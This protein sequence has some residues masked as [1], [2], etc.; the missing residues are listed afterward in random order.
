M[1]VHIF[2]ARGELYG[3]TRAADANNLP[4]D[5]APWVLLQQTCNPRRQ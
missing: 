3:F 1:R 2:K 5:N 4:A